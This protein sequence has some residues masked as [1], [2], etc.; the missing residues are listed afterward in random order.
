MLLLSARDV[1]L[2]QQVCVLDLSRD[3][4]FVTYTVHD[5][6]I[7]AQVGKSILWLLLCWRLL[8]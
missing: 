6:G 4:C 3:S 1:Q 7:F 2:G 8:L 5:N